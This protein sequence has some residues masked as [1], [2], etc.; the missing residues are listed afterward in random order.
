ML[1]LLKYLS[2]TAYWAFLT[3]SLLMTCPWELFS[4][5]LALNPPLDLSFEPTSW[6]AHI[7]AYGLLGL[8]IQETTSH[9]L[10]LQKGL[11]ILAVCHGGACEYLQ[12]FIPNRWPN[13]WD[14]FSNCLGLVMSL[15]LHKVL[16]TQ[17]QIFLSRIFLKKPAA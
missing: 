8:L 9:R 5:K 4:E 15:G 6:L 3:K 2:L 13:G 12:S 17:T 7:G 10:K 1:Q 11:L 14:M 16:T